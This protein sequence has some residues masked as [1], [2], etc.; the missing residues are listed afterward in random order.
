[1]ERVHSIHRERAHRIR[2]IKMMFVEADTR[3][4]RRSRS[5]NGANGKRQTQSAERKIRGK[6]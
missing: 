1:M 5:F 4:Y 2:A 6:R 3:Q